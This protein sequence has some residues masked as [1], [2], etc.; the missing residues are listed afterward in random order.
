MVCDSEPTI[1]ADAVFIDSIDK[2]RL[3]SLTPLDLPISPKR[4][5]SRPANKYS[6]QPQTPAMNG[7]FRLTGCGKRA[8]RKQKAWII[9][10]QG[11]KAMSILLHL[12]HD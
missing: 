1:P 8:N 4:I 3:C 12:R 6:G 7:C 2:K 9:H 11:L 10:P 5:A